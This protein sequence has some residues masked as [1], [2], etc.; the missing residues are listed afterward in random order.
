MIGMLKDLCCNYL[1]NP[2]PCRGWRLP[3]LLGAQLLC[4]ER[5]VSFINA[6][7]THPYVCCQ[8]PTLNDHA[9]LK[10]TKTYTCHVYNTRGCYDNPVLSV[11]PQHITSHNVTIPTSLISRPSHVTQRMREKSG[12]AWLILW[13]YNDVVSATI[14]AMIWTS[15]QRVPTCP[16]NRYIATITINMNSGWA[17]CGVVMVVTD[18]MGRYSRIAKMFKLWQKWWQMHHHYIKIN[19]TFPVFLACIENMGTRL[20]PYNC[21]I[22]ERTMGK[23]W[24][25]GRGSCQESRWREIYRVL[26]G[27]TSKHIYGFYKPHQRKNGV[28]RMVLLQST[29]L[30]WLPCT[31]NIQPILKQ[32]TTY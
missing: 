7:L 15:W 20:P 13:Y 29:T 5:V 11:I 14:S 25:A 12:K 6:F 18:C 1:P 23:E 26:P 27:Q 28:L 22:L 17:S 3:F 21:E 10:Y 19:Q 8:L 9:C 31:F 32:L 24:W 4:L 2:F 30:W 16:C